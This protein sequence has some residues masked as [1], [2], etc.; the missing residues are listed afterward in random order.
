MNSC[1]S[2]VV[3]SL[4]TFSLISCADSPGTPFIAFERDFSDFRHWPRI[5]VTTSPPAGHPAGPRF[6]YRKPDR[7]SHSE[8]AGFTYFRHG[9][10]LV[11]TIESGA[12]ST[13]RIFA[14]VKRG[15]NFN[16]QGAVGWEFFDLAIG[17][18]DRVSIRARGVRPGVAYDS[19]NETE[20]TCND[21]HG[22][23]AA[24]ERDSVLTDGLVP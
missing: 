16:A 20:V 21:C 3:L 4:A 15:G 2:G 1:Q 22:T 19:T 13:W 18:D 8:D 10:I 17:P 5:E 24:R 6:V 12:P 11:K 7:L 14:M 9:T 23:R